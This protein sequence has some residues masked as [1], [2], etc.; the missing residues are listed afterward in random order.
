MEDLITSYLQGTL[1]QDESLALEK[2]MIEDPAFREEVEHEKELYNL[3]KQDYLASLSADL[4][5]FH[6]EYKRKKKIKKGVFSA[7]AIGV[8]AA[9]GLVVFNF[10]AGP[11][12]KRFH[13]KSDVVIELPKEKES[14]KDKTKEISEESKKSTE[15]NSSTLT[16]KNR[17][18]PKPVENKKIS[19]E[20]DS[21]ANEAVIVTND[22]VTLAADEVTETKKEVESTVKLNEFST[23]LV[24]SVIQPTIENIA[25]PSIKC[26]QPKVEVTVVP[27]NEGESN[28]EIIIGS[29]LKDSLEF[30]I[31]ELENDFQPD[32]VYT[33]LE[34]GAYQLS[35][36]G[37]DGCLYDLG[38]HV[39]LT[40]P[41]MKNKDL[42]FN[43]TVQHEINLKSIGS[44]ELKITSLLGRQVLSSFNNEEEVVWDGMDENGNFCALGLYKVTAIYNN[45]V[46]CVYNVVIQN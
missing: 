11:E 40:D 30:K 10:F 2:R 28:G 22:S 18:S 19:M 1:P 32:P 35:A 21:G 44:K 12:K 38:S 6:K 34:E 4:S 14:I 42:T 36:K 37:A 46:T 43:K 26:V 23:I 29:S 39:V 9:L 33:Y 27:A 24:D 31:A 25:S 5:A 41:C 15:V 16:L 20:R 3:V 8:F 13:V 17:T 45:N 7:V